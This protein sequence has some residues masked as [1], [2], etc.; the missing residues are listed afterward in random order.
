MVRNKNPSM[1]LHVLMMVVAYCR[2]GELLQSM[3]EDMIR[4]IH[5]VA[6]DWSTAPPRHST[7]CAEQNTELRRHDRLGKQVY[8]WITKVAAVVAAG[9]PSERTFEYRYEDFTKEFRRANTC[10]GAEGHCS[11]PVPP[12]WGVTGQSGTT[13]RHAGDQKKRGRWKSDNSIARY[14]KSGRMAQIQ[15]DVN[16]SQRTN[17]EATDLALEEFIFGRHRVEDAL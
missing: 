9:R 8:P 4:P 1:A 3:R 15:S 7:R 6:S 12:F 17:F 10:T 14:E 16:N 11:V 13:P 2:P 5:G